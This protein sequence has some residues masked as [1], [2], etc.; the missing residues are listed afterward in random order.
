[1]RQPPALV[2]QKPRRS[3]RLL[4]DLV[5]C[6]VAAEGELAGGTEGTPDGAARLRGDAQRASLRVAHHDRLHRV[7]AVELVKRLC[8]QAAVR[9]GARHGLERAQT[10]RGLE[11]GAQ[12]SRHVAHLVERRGPARGPRQHLAAPVRGGVVHGKPLVEVCHRHREQSRLLFTHRSHDTDSKISSARVCLTRTAPSS[13]SFCR[14]ARIVI[15]AA[16]VSSSPSSEP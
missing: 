8:G 2:S 12:R 1:M 7:P 5:R 16:R 4:L 10:K 11:L 9:V 13:A 3:D 15:S 14:C 6:Q